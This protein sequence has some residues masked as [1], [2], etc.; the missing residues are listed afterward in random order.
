M[1]F[2]S[3]KTVKMNTCLLVL[4]L[5]AGLVACGNGNQINGH[6][7]KT[8]NKSIK[9]IKE[10]L[11]EDSKLEYELSFW[12]LRDEFK[13][14]A[15]FL[16]AIDGKTPFELM[17]LGQDSFNR[18]KAGGL[19]AYQNFTDWQAML[20]DYSQKRATQS[21]PSVNAGKDAKYKGSVIYN[22]RTKSQQ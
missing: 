1:T 19:A 16:N 11:P 7:L 9:Y 18:R 13:E 2:E 22:P 4:L 14:D 8:A 20:T 10:R 17:E 3:L 15:Q 5:V 6:T 21:K 12:T